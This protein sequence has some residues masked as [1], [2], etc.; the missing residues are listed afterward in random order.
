[1]RTFDV[2][3]RTR[4]LV[5]IAGIRDGKL[6]RGASGR[7]ELWVDGIVSE[8]RAGDRLRVFAQ[9]DT[10]SRAMN[11]GQFDFAEYLRGDR[12]L[13]HLNTEHAQCVTPLGGG[14]SWSP[15]RL[16]D[17]VRLDGR[18]W[19]AHYLDPRRS[20]LAAAVLLGAREQLDPEQSEAFMETGTVHLLV[21]AGLHVAIL[22]TAL[23]TLLRHLALPR[24]WASGM[25]A[26][27]VVFY[28]FLTD[29]E[30]PVVRATVLVLSLCLALAV[31]RRTQAFN[32]LAAAALV[33]L[34]LNPS[35]LFHV[36]AQLSFLSVAGLAWFAQRSAEKQKQAVLPEE[37]EAGRSRPARCCAAWV[38][39]S[40]TR[41]RW[42]WCSGR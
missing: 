10:P 36:G 20:S 22:V 24:A 41:P 9:L 12:Q 14:S 23:W 31:G 40:G 7:V 25:V 34:A 16:I 3:D 39:G 6:W 18:H 19:L 30:P 42:A 8:V 1:M 2:G 11:P 13:C 26:A 38:A 33:V 4:L 32:I 5:E 17:N 21:V 35:D 37:T 27:V 15:R 28:M 29:A